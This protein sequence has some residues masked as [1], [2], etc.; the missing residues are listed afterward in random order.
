MSTSTKNQSK[1]LV[2][3]GSSTVKVYKQKGSAVSPLFTRSIPFKE[4]FDQDIGIYEPNKTE[5]FE[6]LNEIKDKH[7]DSQ[8]KLYA[9]ALYRKLTTKAK[10][11]LIYEVFVRTGLFFNIISHELENFYLEI[12]LVGKYTKDEPVLLVNIG[13]G[14]TELVAMY[15]N[16]A[17][18]KRNIDFG[19]GTILTNFPKLNENYSGHDLQEVVESIKEKLPEL[20]NG[21]S[22]AIYNGGELTY[23]RLAKY[24]LDKNLIFSDPNHPN[25]ISAEYFLKRNREIYSEVSINDLKNLMPDNPNWMLGSRACCAIAQAVFDKYNVKTIVP[26]D[27][28]LIDGVVRQEFRYVTISG[29]FRKHLPYILEARKKLV[30]G[31]VQVLSSRFTEPK[32]PGE[33]FVVFTGEENATPL[34]LERHH[35]DSINR[36]DALIVCDPEGYVGASALIEIGYAQSIG[37]RIIFTEKPE[38]FMLNT[39]PREVGL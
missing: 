15:G 16:E 35:L 33:E 20:Q 36:S 31:K 37:K 8:I 32:N 25:T 22:T 18:E 29:S 21:F 13:G 34:E 38:E 14:S 7:P 24:K 10:T 23:M 26:S 5:L 3:I 17:V 12:A 27:S 6:L 19:V 9:T 28:N 2:D 1:I 30:E 39:L 4:R 11:E